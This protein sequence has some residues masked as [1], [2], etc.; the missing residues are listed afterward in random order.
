MYWFQNLEEVLSPL[1]VFRYITVRAFAGAATAFLITV[2]AAPRVIERLRRLRVS[3]RE[4]RPLDR[5]TP[6][7]AALRRVEHELLGLG[8]MI[9]QRLF[10]APRRRTNV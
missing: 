7:D 10:L 9:E 2:A 1:R 3:Q 5:A 8:V 4:R 6:V